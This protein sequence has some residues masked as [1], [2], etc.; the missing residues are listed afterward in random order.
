MKFEI[1]F[2]DGEYVSD[3]SALTL[4]AKL[5]GTVEGL[6][7]ADFLRGIVVLLEMS[8]KRYA[9]PTPLGSALTILVRRKACNRLALFMRIDI[10]LHDGLAKAS[11]SCDDN[12]RT[13]D[14]AVAVAVSKGDDV[15]NI[16]RAVLDAV[17]EERQL[18]TLV[19]SRLKSV[20]RSVKIN[21]EE[22]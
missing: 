10:A 17:Y 5:S 2:Y 22:L 13:F 21:P 6:A 14:E 11:L 20:G 12:V 3:M 8:E 1:E 15:V 4:S 9:T 16:A 19:E 18:S 7:P